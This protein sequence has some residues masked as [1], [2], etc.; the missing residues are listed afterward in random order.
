M[1]KHLVPSALFTR[2]HVVASLL[3]LTIL[4]TPTAAWA[5][6]LIFKDSAQDTPETAWIV[7]QPDAAFRYLG[8]LEQKDE[9]D[10]FSLTLKKDQKLDISL[11]TPAADGNFRPIMVFFGPGISRP[12]EDPVIKIGD[13]NGAI[14]LREDKEPR[15]SFFDR[16]TMTTYYQG[17]TFKFIAPRDATYGLAIRSP[18]GDTGRYILRFKGKDEFA[19]QNLLD[20]VVNVFRAILRM[21]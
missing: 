12:K 15:D 4:A 7:R 19:W 11:E 5:E 21:Y 3:S 13:P 8:R 20:F 18:K 17:P 10:Y 14:I 16:L 2:P 1:P 9:A 6:S